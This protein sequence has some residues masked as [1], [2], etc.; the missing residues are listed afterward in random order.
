M[1]WELVEIICS[2]PWIDDEGETL[3]KAY[4]TKVGESD[5]LLADLKREYPRQE[6]GQ[7]TIVVGATDVFHKKSQLELSKATRLQKKD[8]ARWQRNVVDM[9]IHGSYQILHKSMEKAKFNQA[10]PPPPEAV[11]I[12]EEHEIDLS[13]DADEDPVQMGTETDLEELTACHKGPNGHKDPERLKAAKCDLERLQA[14]SRA[15]R[16]HETFSAIDSL[17]EFKQTRVLRR[18]PSADDVTHLDVSVDQSA[19]VEV[20]F[21]VGG[22]R[23]VKLTVSERTSMD[24]LRRIVWTHLNSRCR[25]APDQFPLRNGPEVRVSPLFV[26]LIS[27]D[28]S[29]ETIVP[30]LKYNEHLS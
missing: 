25:V 15:A 16:A 21:C 2:W 29:M 26:P 12:L 5:V 3:E 10:N 23:D 1:K 9:G 24:E 18:S 11:E 30:Y 22:N 14:L 27:E 8:L 19:Q 17:G 7:A 28:A 20:T 13:P 6:V 4:R